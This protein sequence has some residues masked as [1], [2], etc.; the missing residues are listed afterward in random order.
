ME[1]RYFTFPDSAGE[2]IARACALA[3]QYIDILAFGQAQRGSAPLP[4]ADFVRQLL[5]RCAVEF[6]R[7][8]AV[9]L[10]RQ[11]A[12]GYVASPEAL[13]RA[14]ALL[15]Q[16]GSLTA[17]FE[18]ERLRLAPGRFNSTRLERF[19]HHIPEPD[20]TR[21]RR[22]AEH[23]VPIPVP[24]N[25]HPAPAPTKR[26]R[27]EEQLGS[28][29]A[30]HF[31]EAAAAGVAV[32]FREADI[33]AELLQGVGYLSL[34][35]VAKRSE[36]IP[37]PK[38]R[39]CLDPSNVEGGDSINSPDLRIRNQAPDMSGAMT[40][41]TITAILQEAVEHADAA[42]FPLKDGRFYK[43]DVAHAFGQMS[44]D[45]T[46]AKLSAVR[47]E[48]EPGLRERAKASSHPGGIPQFIIF[49]LLHVYF[50]WCGAS[51]AFAVFSRALLC[52]LKPALKGVVSIFVDDLMG[53]A[54][55]SH[56]HT[57]QAI[58]QDTLRAFFGPLAVAPKSVTPS[59]AVELIGWWVDLTLETIRPSDRAC[60]KLLWAFFNAPTD[61]NCTWPL[62][63]CQVLASLANRY[64][65]CIRAMRPFVQ[66]FDE[67]LQGS[68]NTKRHVK[69]PVRFAVEVWRTVA[70]ILVTTP[71]VLA[72]PIR[73]I[74]Q[75]HLVTRCYL[76]TDAG[77]TRLGIGLFRDP[78]MTDLIGYA[79]YPLPFNEELTKLP[80]YQNTREFL[81]AVIG[82]LLALQVQ[83][84]R[85]LPTGP[86]AI[87]WTGDNTSALSW[88]TH[89]K[90][91]SAQTQKSFMAYT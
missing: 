44:F 50:G 86:I 58:L 39:I 38:G 84:A 85:H 62:Q 32:G 6:S 28:T 1:D 47:I 65:E 41:P 22:F 34:H 77:P 63:L 25:Y 18:A 45:A 80:D 42:G 9:A 48:T 55:H 75:R 2:H 19:A 21:L 23:G 36:G 56:A 73:S 31:L 10:A 57:D 74:A 46:A 29:H 59:P 40:N 7:E 53:F 16:H 67:L 89:R 61:T 11:D 24:E 90:A 14:T 82:I 17:I 69:S 87:T 5:D 3:V 26:R 30:K 49:F 13:N 54:H 71:Q 64:S 12:S 81:G 8:S 66:P 91:K 4:T 70:C 52:I 83:L 72:T 60:R 15:Q 51:P 43:D 27:L 68:A 76:K 35:W 20:L 33:P 88:I 79:D 78:L 37:V